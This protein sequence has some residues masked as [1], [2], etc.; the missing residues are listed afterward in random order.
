VRERFAVPVRHLVFEPGSDPEEPDK[1][2]EARYRQEFD[3]AAAARKG[4]VVVGA[5]AGV[6]ILAA[7]LMSTVALIRSEQSTP[8]PKVVDLKVISSYKLGPDGTKHDAFTKTNFAVK[9]GQPMELRIDNTDKQ[10]PLVA[11]SA[12]R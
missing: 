7:L 1:D 6:G 12:D 3:D 11:G 2:T 5:L 10:E 8:A 4:K 9:L